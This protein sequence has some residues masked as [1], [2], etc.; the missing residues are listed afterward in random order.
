[1]L[2][3]SSR[4][5]TVKAELERGL[6]AATPGHM[7]WCVNKL[8][9]LPTRD[10]TATTAA[11]QADNYIDVCAKF[12][13]DLWTSGTT[14][15][16]ETRTFRPS[17]AEMVE[18]V[19]PKFRERQRMLDR[20]NQML[21]GGK[22]AAALPAPEPETR[23]QRMRITR[24]LY[25]KHN[26]PL[27]VARVDREIAAEVEALDRE[28]RGM[29]R[30]RA[31][32]MLAPVQSEPEPF[33]PADTPTNRRMAELAAQHRSGKPPASSEGVKINTAEPPPIERAPDWA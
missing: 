14:E 11:L 29:T 2:P 18:I 5:R 33:K 20:V 25:E 22:P 27:D 4:L 21:G 19:G 15:L 6:K 7:Q 31:A 32:A 16:L 8:F 12:P 24:G 23:L 10:G 28:A 3:D 30:A 17:P 9:A 26:R 1:M 13:D